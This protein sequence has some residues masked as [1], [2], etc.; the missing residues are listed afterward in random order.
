M[1]SYF[2]RIS[3]GS[4]NV[5]ATGLLSLITVPREL[6]E[7]TGR[8]THTLLRTMA[9]SLVK[10]VILTDP[11]RKTK[12]KEEIRLVIICMKNEEKYRLIPIE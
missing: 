6:T 12:N 3:T 4:S 11:A 5:L 2:Y 8:H 9:E 10:C 1:I 7:N